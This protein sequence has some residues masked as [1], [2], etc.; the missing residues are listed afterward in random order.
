[1]FDFET[2]VR[3]L[4]SLRPTRRGAA[5]KRSNRRTTAFECLEELCCPSTV[6]L[7]LGGAGNYSNA[8]NWSLGVVPNNGNSYDGQ[9]ATFT[10]E[11]AKSSAVTL[12]INPTIDNLSIDATSSLSI[13]NDQSLTVVGSGSGTGTINNSGTIA[14]EA[15][16]YGASLLAS[17]NVSL[18]GGGTV[19]MSNSSENLIDQATSNSTLTNV[20][21]TIQ[22]SGDIGDNGLSLNNQSL[23]DANQSSE[24]LVD[25]PAITNT[26]T[27]EATVG[28]TL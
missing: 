17:G 2:K 6:D 25:A 27:L 20:N 3:H 28:G 4:R 24:L 13:P 23:I 22:G 8:A 19:T 11:I 14:L 9:P 5:G 7:W 21:N 16:G 10:V 12:D 15:T 26:G 18:T 1:M